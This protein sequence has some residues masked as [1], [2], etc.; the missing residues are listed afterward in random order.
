MLFEIRSLAAAKLLSP[1]VLWMRRTA[2]DLS[3]DERSRR[4]GP[5]E[6]SCMSSARYAG[7]L[8]YDERLR[9][10]GLLRLE[11]WRLHL[12]CYKMVFGLMF[13]KKIFNNFSVCLY[14]SKMHQQCQS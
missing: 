1:K 14:Q 13:F 9:Q 5:S 2:H 8:A 6:T 11:L 10:L 7:C 12:F 4:R 3:A